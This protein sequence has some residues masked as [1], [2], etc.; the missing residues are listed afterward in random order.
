MNEHEQVNAAL[1]EKSEPRK[2]RKGPAERMW[3][4]IKIK[5]TEDYHYV[6]KSIWL[7]ILYYI[8]MFVGMPYVYLFF[9]IKWGFGVIDKKNAKL[10]KGIPAI[11]VANHIHNMD[12]PMLTYAFY[13]SAPYFIA[14]KHNLEAFI[15]GGIVKILRGVPL[16]L[17]VKNFENFSQQISELLSTTTRKVHL[18][19]EG[20]IMPYCK[21]LRKFKNGAFYFAVKNNVPVLPLTFVVPKKKRVKLIVGKPVFLKDV[22]GADGLSEPRQ[23]ILFSKHVKAVMQKMLDDYYGGRK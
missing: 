10:V 14:L 16:P 22:P 3:A 1:N 13:P 18:Y 2:R 9:K 21:E 17:D 4:P 23:I 12:S 8:F 15:V 5:F 20:E 19:P 11:T 6:T 7:R